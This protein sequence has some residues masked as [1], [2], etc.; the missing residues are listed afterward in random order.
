MVLAASGL[1]KRREMPGCDFELLSRQ[2]HD[3]RA[4]AATSHPKAAHPGQRTDRRDRRPS[5]PRAVEIAAD[6]RGRPCLFVVAY[7]PK[8]PQRWKNG[9]V[10]AGLSI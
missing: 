9:N 5:R 4:A 7:S 6:V 10:L 2:D 3:Q 8:A 1:T